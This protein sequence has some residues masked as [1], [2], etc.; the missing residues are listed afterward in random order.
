[1]LFRCFVVCCVLCVVVVSPA[2]GMKLGVQ[3]QARQ[4]RQHTSLEGRRTH[5]SCPR[6][7]RVVA[8][9]QTATVTVTVTARCRQRVERPSRRQ[10]TAAASPRTYWPRGGRGGA[11]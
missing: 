8:T 3:L 10:T 5:L 4:H 6:P 11:G 7:L 1:M 2:E 9:R